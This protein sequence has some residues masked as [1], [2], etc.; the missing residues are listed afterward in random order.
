[1]DALIQTYGGVGVS[2]DY[3]QVAYGYDLLERHPCE[4][5]VAGDGRQDRLC[6]VG[7]VWACSVV[8]HDELRW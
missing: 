4:A 5:I 2:Y 6:V 3:E 7:S 8:S 1:M